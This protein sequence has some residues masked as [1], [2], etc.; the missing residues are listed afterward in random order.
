MNSPDQEFLDN[1]CKIIDHDFTTEPIVNDSG[2]MVITMERTCNRC[3]RS[4][5]A[6][7]KYADLHIRKY[8]VLE[9][10][11]RQVDEQFNSSPHKKL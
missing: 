8:P 6:V 11:K 2:R 1:I 7:I 9:R 5:K 4:G 10:A 3:G